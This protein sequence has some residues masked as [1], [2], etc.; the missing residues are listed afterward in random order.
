[1]K[2]PSW[3]TSAGALVALATSAAGFLIQEGVQREA[4]RRTDQQLDRVEREIEKSHAGLQR[5]VDLAC[6]CCRNH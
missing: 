3:I 2:P 6:A 4:Q 5:E 1:M